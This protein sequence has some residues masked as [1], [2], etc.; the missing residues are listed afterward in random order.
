LRCHEALICLKNA[1]IGSNKQKGIVIYQ[2]VVSKLV[3]LLGDESKPLNIR[4]ECA[5]V[6]GKLEK[7]EKITKNTSPKIHVYL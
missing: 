3:Q 4:V 1:V 5:I 7:Y 6:I 2:G